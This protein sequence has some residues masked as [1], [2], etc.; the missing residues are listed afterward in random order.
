MV[1]IIL[2][3]N[4]ITA[5]FAYYFNKRLLTTEPAVKII[6]FSFLGCAIFSLVAILAARQPFDFNYSIFAVG[7]INSYGALFSTKA[8][9]I[10]LAQSMI[11]LPLTGFVGILLAVLFLGEGSFLNPLKL[12]GFLAVL[13]VAGSFLAMLFFINGTCAVRQMRKRWALYI[14]GQTFISGAAIFFIKYMAIQNIA[15]TS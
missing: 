13:G 6:T 3:V 1:Y 14:I 2:F 15:I 10:N 8:I 9:K 5:I 4:I 11:F 12:N 7:L